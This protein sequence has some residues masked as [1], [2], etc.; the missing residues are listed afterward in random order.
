[1]SKKY[2]EIMADQEKRGFIEKICDTSDPVEAQQKTLHYIPHHPVRKDSATTPVRIVYDCSCKQSQSSSSLNDCLQSTP[3]V[4]NDLTD[5]LVRFRL[6][7]V[8]VSTD[9]EKT[10]LHVGLHEKDRDATQFFWLDDPRNPDSELCTYRFKVVLFEATCSPFILNATILKHLGSQKNNLTAE[11][12]WRDLNVDNILSSFPSETETT[13]YYTESRDLML[14]AGFNL[15]SWTS[16]SETLRQIAKR[17][18]ILDTDESTK[19]L[20]MRWIVK[21]DNMAFA[22]QTIPQLTNVTKR[23]ILKYS[24]RIYDPLGFLSPVTMRAKT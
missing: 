17:D 8:A 9:V 19:V 22:I 13:A 24:S 15:R 5:L 23:L 20:G 21:D 10:F 6:N 18:D 12:I 7:G 14:Q 1:M 3:P 2:G 4:L 16:N 11:I